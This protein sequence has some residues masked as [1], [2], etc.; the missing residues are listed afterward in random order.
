MCPNPRKQEKRGK[1]KV[2]GIVLRIR[3]DCHRGLTLAMLHVYSRRLAVAFYSCRGFLF[4]TWFFVF[5]L[6]LYS[7]PGPLFSTWLSVLDLVLYPWPSSAFLRP[8]FSI[9]DLALYSCRVSLVLPCCFLVLALYSCLG[10]LVPILALAIFSHWRSVF[11]VAL[12][13]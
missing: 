8:S 6:F 4:L 13:S 10:S 5:G 11:A 9:F 1:Q 3:K 7:W 12:L 2:T